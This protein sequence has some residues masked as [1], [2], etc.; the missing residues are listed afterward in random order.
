MSWSALVGAFIGAGIPTI[1]GYIK[2]LKGV[3]P[4]RCGDTLCGLGLCDWL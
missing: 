4:L 2:A 3:A 1:L